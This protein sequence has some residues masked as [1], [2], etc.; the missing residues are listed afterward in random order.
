[1]SKTHTKSPVRRIR[2]SIVA[3]PKLV[4]ECLG[5]LIERNTDF[6]LAVTT[7]FDSDRTRSSKFKESDIAV[8]YLE[9][10]DSAEIVRT[11][12]VDFPD[13]KIVAIT[14][15]DDID[16]S[17]KALKF[18]AVGIVRAVQGSNL[19]IEAIRKAYEGETWLDQELLS[20]LLQ[21]NDGSGHARSNGKNGKNGHN[22]R[23]GPA[24]D[25]LSP[26]EIE[27]IAMIGKG[28]K[29][30]AIAEQMSISEA[31]VRHHLSSIYG[32][33]GVDDRLNLVIYAFEKGLLQLG[34]D[35]L[36]K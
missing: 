29:S 35:T 17:I 18:G 25:A 31:T 4:R 3:N 9:P 26:R 20:N 5:F 28:L 32:K 16:C 7:G 6:S 8:V 12:R 22:G 33:L 15:G 21:K 19:L 2:I 36:H 14:D 1:M 13:V 27:V 10:G 11:L 23:F 24:N 34:H 30:K